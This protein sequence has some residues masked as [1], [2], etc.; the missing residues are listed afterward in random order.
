[1]PKDDEVI[2]KMLSFC[3]RVEAMCVT[4]KSA[5]EAMRHAAEAVVHQ[6]AWI[7][8]LEARI[9]TLEQFFT[10]EQSCANTMAAVAEMD[11]SD[12]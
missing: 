8:N 1:M 4:L 2:A 10:Q 6:Q 7:T 11:D 5:D 12:G 3:E 9:S